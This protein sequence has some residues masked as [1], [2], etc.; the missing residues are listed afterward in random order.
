MII[1]GRDNK[2]LVKCYQIASEIDNGKKV[3]FVT[4]RLLYEEEYMEEMDKCNVYN[5][6]DEAMALIEKQNEY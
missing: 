3:Y 4:T 5:T 2:R 1:M 6:Y